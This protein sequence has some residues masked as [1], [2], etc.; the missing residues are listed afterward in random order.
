MKIYGLIMNAFGAVAAL[1]VGVMTA[2]VSYDVIVRNLGLG[3]LDWVLEVSE[4]MLPVIICASAPWLMYR[5]QHI[6]LD[7][8]NM[9]LPT[10]VLR[11]IDRYA[12]SVGAVVSLIFAWYALLLLLDSRAA[13]SLVMKSLVFPEWWLFVPVPI[14]F[15]ALAVECAR[16]AFMPETVADE[17]APAE[18]VM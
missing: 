13:G 9:V 4:Y 10:R 16:R 6:R 3:S 12:A 2:L 14:G 8:L 7:V 1:L 11:R 18:G 17:A 5:N 15:G